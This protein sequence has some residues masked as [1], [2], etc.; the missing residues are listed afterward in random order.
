MA[1]KYQL[2]TPLLVP[3]IPILETA[4]PL[5]GTDNRIV[6]EKARMY[7]LSAHRIA[8]RTFEDNGGNMRDL[9]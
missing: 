1:Y 8:A 5:F 9:G 3:I 2:D 7:S 6:Y 4:S